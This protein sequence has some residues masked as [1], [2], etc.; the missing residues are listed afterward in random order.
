[1]Q[2]CDLEQQSIVHIVQRSR[3]GQEADAPGGDE[4][5]TALG[6]PEREPKSLTRVDLSSSVLPADSVGLAVVLDTGSRR[7]S[8][9]AGGP[10]RPTYNSFYVYCKG[11]CQGVQPG[12]LRVRCGTCRCPLFP[13]CLDVLSL[14]LA[15]APFQLVTSRGS[16]L[17]GKD[18]R[19][20]RVHCGI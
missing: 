9:A 15:P 18:R 5:R 10:G 6:G 16:P 4:P 3:R 2:N 8:T 14:V 19:Y 7:D 20:I 11:P 12:K 13:L 1:M 17:L